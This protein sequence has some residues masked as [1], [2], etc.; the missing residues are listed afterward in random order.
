MKQLIVI[1]DVI[2]KRRGKFFGNNIEL[3]KRAVERKYN[4]PM[5]NE[6]SAEDEARTIAE[7]LHGSLSELSGRLGITAMTI[8]NEGSGRGRLWPL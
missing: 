3:T 5:G 1:Y 8:S 4:K 2:D 7:K 6:R